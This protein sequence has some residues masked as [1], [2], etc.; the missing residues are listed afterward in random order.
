M[1]MLIP[2]VTW[3]AVFVKADQCNA[4]LMRELMSLF[5]M[6]QLSDPLPSLARI[7]SVCQFN[8]FYYKARND[9]ILK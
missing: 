2:L 9:K 8:P 3:M 5:L 6:L 7:T 1:E 4:R